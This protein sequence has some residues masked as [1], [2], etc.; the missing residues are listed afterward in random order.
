[1]TKKSSPLKRFL[2]VLIFLLALA[3]VAYGLQRYYHV[4]DAPLKEFN[5]YLSLANGIVFKKM[6]LG[7]SGGTLIFIALLII[8]SILMRNINTR[9]YFK[10]LFQGIISAFIF[11][12]TQ[13]LYAFLVETNRFYFLLA[14]VGIAVITLILIR[15]VTLMYKKKADQVEFRTAYIAG[16]TAGLIFGVLMQ[17]ATM[18]IDWLKVNAHLGF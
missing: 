14:M 12:V 2:K 18:G 5:H 4:F 3:G 17:L 6:I 8:F 16:I 15:I 10:N 9:S 13:T 7:I 11:F 1:M